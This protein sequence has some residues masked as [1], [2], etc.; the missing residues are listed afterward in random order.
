MKNKKVYKEERNGSS[1]KK[2]GISANS[3]LKTKCFNTYN[4]MNNCS[5]SKMVTIG[6][7]TLPVDQARFEPTSHVY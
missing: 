1:M 5:N 7:I 2:E 4:F 6:N 3:I